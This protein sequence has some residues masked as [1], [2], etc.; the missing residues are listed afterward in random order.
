MNDNERNDLQITI[1][2]AL[3]DMKSEVGGSFD[4]SKVNLA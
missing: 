1:S 4:I 3:H 2:H